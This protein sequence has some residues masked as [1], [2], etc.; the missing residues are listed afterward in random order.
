MLSA[1]IA[2]ELVVKMQVVFAEELPAEI[3]ARFGKM[4][5]ISAGIANACGA[6]AFGIEFFVG[7]LVNPGAA[8]K[9][10]VR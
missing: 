4:V 6:G 7:E 3:F 10:R 8:A 9:I 5:E 2:H 1:N